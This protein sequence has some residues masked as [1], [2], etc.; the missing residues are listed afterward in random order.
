MDQT[1]DLQAKFTAMFGSKG[2]LYR[3]PG[4]VNLIGEHTDYNQG[5][6]LPAALDLSCWAAASRREDNKLVIYSSNFGESVEAELDDRH[7]RAVGKWWDYPL[8][9]A[10]ALQ[11][12][13]YRLQGANLYIRGDVPLGAGLSASAAIEVCVGYALLDLSGNA[14]DRSRLA[15]LCQRAENEF[16]G[17][18]CGIMDQFISCH[19]RAGHALLLDCRSLDYRMVP[20]PDRMQLV[21]CNTM[22]KHKLA[23]SGY[24]TRR[25]EC[26]E[27]VR[28]LAEVLPHIGSLRDVTLAELEQHRG[29]LTETIYKR[30]RHVITENDRVHKLASALASGDTSALNQ[31]TADSHRSLRDDY[32]VSCAELD[33]MVELACQQKGVFGARMTGGGFGGSTVNFVNAADAPEFRQ[34]IAAAYHAATGVTPDIYVCEASEGAG[35]MDLAAAQSIVQSHKGAAQHD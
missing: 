9:V 29:R 35:A 27:G 28:R 31:W 7:L 24:N 4:R 16:V 33:L 11:Q 17:M 26:E 18:H 32:Q 19:G 25:A 12:A 23:A 2:A 1:L 21:I 5:F 3:A 15:L 6:V 20:L 22:V 10:W 8:G 14:I 13:G 30:C 34:R